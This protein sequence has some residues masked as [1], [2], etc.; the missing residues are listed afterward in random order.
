MLPL[1]PVYRLAGVLLLVWLTINPAFSQSFT[2][3]DT[4]P[5]N[6]PDSLEAWLRANPKAPALTRLKNLISLERTYDWMY[7]NKMGAHHKAI[8]RLLPVAQNATA[9]ASYF[10]LKASSFYLL[11]RMGEAAQY[12]SQA[13]SLF[14]NEADSSGLVHVYAL[15]AILN[16]SLDYQQATKNN[17]LFK[18][19]IAKAKRYVNPQDDPHEQ[20]YVLFTDCNLQLEEDNY[21]Q[22][23]LSRQDEFIKQALQIIDRNP[24][25]HYAK[26]V[27][28]VQKALAYE[29]RKDYLNKYKI[30]RELL[31]S[32]AEDQTRELA[33]LYIN[34]AET[35]YK[36]GRFDE[37][38]LYNTKCRVYAQKCPPIMYNRYLEYIY[39]LQS[40]IAASQKDFSTAY[41]SIV[42]RDSIIAIREQEK[43]DQQMLNLTARFKFDQQEQ[44]N[45]L[46]QQQQ[47]AAQ[48]QNRVY[49]TSL[50]VA[51]V[52]IALFIWLWLR[53]RQANAQLAHALTEVQQLNTARDH[54]IG[55]IAHDMRKPLVSFRGLAGLVADQL[56]Q[57]AYNDIQLLSQAI[58][59]SGLQI[60]TMLDNLLRWALAQREIIPY[61]P[62]KLHLNTLLHQVTDLYQNLVRF[63]DI[64]IRVDCPDDL[65]V[66][67][68][69]NGLQLIV[70]NLIDNALKHLGSVGEVVIQAQATANRQ[71]RISIQDTGKGIA[72][73][74][75][76]FLQG[77]LG[78]T[79]S[80]HVG[81]QGLGLGLVL[82]RDFAARNKGRVEVVSLPEQG[83]CFTIYMPTAQEQSALV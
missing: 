72:S 28:Y 42:L 33:T 6:N 54:F 8:E 77:F 2:F 62:Q 48:F 41:R 23:D 55:I 5:I 80:G 27:F 47:Q 70:R 65:H 74:Q 10:Y 71:I 49:L 19:F 83:T 30:E 38:S 81:Q 16:S 50:A 73:E 44:E 15:L 51:L 43:A 63:Q 7:F 61:K 22:A 1:F 34:L 57:R 64:Q 46:L 78:G 59:E 35:C 58:D 52:L 14:Q 39:S 76:A 32:Y 40:D 17:A 20:L 66:W 79:V 37:A 67:A 29:D 31:S 56:R 11:S 12:A 60:E 21:T 26:N 25:C 82:V 24:A 53:L 13:A 36:L 68:D 4:H 75:L 3:A 9:K 45:R 69:D 18:Q